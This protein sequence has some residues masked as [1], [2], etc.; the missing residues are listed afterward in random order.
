MLW[1]I[2]APL[3]YDGY[4]GDAVIKALNMSGQGPPFL[5]RVNFI[6]NMDA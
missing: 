6:P 4:N 1:Y 2:K 5:T 3:T